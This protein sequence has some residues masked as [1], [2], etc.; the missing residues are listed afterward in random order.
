MK[1]V[2]VWVLGCVDHVLK[3]LSRAMCLYFLGTSNASHKVSDVKM[4]DY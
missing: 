1:Q 2:G 4:S 3:A